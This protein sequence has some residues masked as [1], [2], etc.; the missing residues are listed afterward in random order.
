MGQDSAVAALRR[1][2]A[3]PVHAYLFVGPP[4]STK[5]EAAKAFAAE[6]LTQRDDPLS[7]D[8]VDQSHLL[9]RH[10]GSDGDGKKA[11]SSGKNAFHGLVGLGVALPGLVPPPESSFWL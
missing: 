9:R 3:A 10:A 5:H 1:A 4:G 2:A 8:A 7:R 6:L 11:N